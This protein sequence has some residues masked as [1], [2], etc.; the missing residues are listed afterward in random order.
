MKTGGVGIEPSEG[1]VGVVKGGWKLV[2]RSKPVVNRDYDR[3]EFLGEHAI[4]KV[5][6]LGK[7]ED[8]TPPWMSSSS[9]CVAWPRSGE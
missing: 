4:S 5:I 9:G 8:V 1:R 6:H 7:A 3:A 2:F